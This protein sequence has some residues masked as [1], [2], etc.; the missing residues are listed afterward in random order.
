MWIFDLDFEGH[1]GRIFVQ[2]RG[3]GKHGYSAPTPAASP[4]NDDVSQ[5]VKN[6]TRIR[7]GSA[8]T[9]TRPDGP[10]ATIAR[11]ATCHLYHML[12][13]PLFIPVLVI[14]FHF[15]FVFTPMPIGFPRTV[16]HNILYVYSHDA[17]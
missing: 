15:R 2:F 1:T 6:K 5:D 10:P 14:V 3:V 11:P 9:R 7:P 17:P 16:S 8:C 12:W 13:L 4:N